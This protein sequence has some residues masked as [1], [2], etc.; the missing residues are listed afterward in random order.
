MN[1]EWKYTYSGS[2]RIEASEKLAENKDVRGVPRSVIAGIINCLEPDLILAIESY[3]MNNELNT[4]MVS[5]AYLLKPIAEG[6]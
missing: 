5:I 1:S 4:V 2:D 6:S 3:G